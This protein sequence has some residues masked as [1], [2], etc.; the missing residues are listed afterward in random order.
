MMV[1]TTNDST[2]WQLN[3]I[4]TQAS[5]W[6]TAN[7]DMS[8]TLSGDATGAA[9][10]TVVGA[11]QGHAISPNTPSTGNGLV[12]NGSAW[13]PTGF[14]IGPTGPTG[15]AGSN[16]TQG[17]TGPTGPAGATGPAGGGSSNLAGDATGPASSNQVWTIS[18]NPAIVE[19]GLSVATGANITMQ[20]NGP[21]S[22]SGEIN[23]SATGTFL[24]ARNAAN[25][26]NIPLMALDG[27]N[28]L[29][30]QSGVGGNILLQ[31]SLNDGSV[32]AAGPSIATVESSS[33]DI[34]RASPGA[35]LFSSVGGGGSITMDIAS[36]TVV[37]VVATGVTIATG[38]T[39]TMQG[40]GPAS[41][42]GEI[43]FSATGTLLAARNAA[44][45]T[46]ISLM[47]LD[48][49][50]DLTMGNIGSLGE[51]TLNAT[52]VLLEVNGGNVV[53]LYSGGFI[54]NS[55]NLTI[56]ST[57]A[58]FDA[59]SPVAINDTLTVKGQQ[60]GSQRVTSN[61]ST[62]AI[63]SGTYQIPTAPP[64][65]TIPFVG[66]QNIGYEIDMMTQ[67]TAAGGINPVWSVPSGV[68]LTLACNGLGAQDTFVHLAGI[69]ATGVGTGAY[70]AANS[71]VN[72]RINGTIT[73]AVGATGPVTIS[74]LPV[75][76]GHTMTVFAGS[77]IYLYPST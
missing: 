38:L 44:N 10:T 51:I 48:G 29:I 6:S 11:I 13:I 23:F 63:C 7:F 21:A 18:G 60:Y 54:I 61:F 39:I 27:A 43:N 32:I 75:V 58:T 64:Q 24:A 69:P 57:S 68:G 56:E 17:A 12:W 40:N 49:F 31:P 66:G 1:Y 19:Y 14:G 65:Y 52:A 28:S 35:I 77:D 15:P 55:T 5:N 36:N 70:G 42:S 2:F 37:S 26:G 34:M 9:A 33:G 22:T 72:L 8:V 4:G 76:A 45:T 47:A 46:D 62:S 20:G 71:F 74:A 30:F 50:N 41:T 73:G 25:T 59:A 67:T 53:E 16:G 3:S